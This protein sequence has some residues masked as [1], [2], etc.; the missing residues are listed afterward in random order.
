MQAAEKDK[1]MQKQAF[2]LFFYGQFQHQFRTF[3]AEK[4][5]TFFW[6]EGITI[7]E[8]FIEE[9]VE[10]LVPRAS[11]GLFGIFDELRRAMS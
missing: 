10:G 3:M 2:D 7:N 1:R 6:G 11:A 4:T 8:D 5:E 9:L